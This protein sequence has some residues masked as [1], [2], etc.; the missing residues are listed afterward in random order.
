MLACSCMLRRVAAAAGLRRRGR[1]AEPADPWELEADAAPVPFLVPQS[2][3][4]R[5]LNATAVIDRLDAR[6]LQPRT[7]A[8]Q[9]DT[10]SQ[11]NKP[12]A[13]V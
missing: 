4:E 13:T 12:N 3:G 2:P 10:R 9:M 8:G 11:C 6:V 1:A 5:T 7:N